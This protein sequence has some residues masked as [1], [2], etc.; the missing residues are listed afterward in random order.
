MFLY[1]ICFRKNLIECGVTSTTSHFNR[2]VGGSEAVLFSWPSMVYITFDY[3]TVVTIADG[4]SLQI[5]KTESCSGILIDKKNILTA[6][7]CL[8]DSISYE[9]L[10]FQY[11]YTIPEGNKYPTKESSYK[12]YLGVHDRAKLSSDSGAVVRSVKNILRV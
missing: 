1:L 5:S 2:I 7:H 11:N 9:Y 12:V 4:V 3:S 6:G 8:I 10:G